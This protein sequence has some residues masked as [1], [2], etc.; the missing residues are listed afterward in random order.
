MFHHTPLLRHDTMTI[1][2]AADDELFDAPSASTWKRL[3]LEQPPT[4][5]IL[6]QCLHV[7]LHHHKAIHP[8]PEELRLRNGRFTAYVIL[9]GISASVSEKEE[10]GQLLPMSP[11]F[12]QH[13]DAL[14]C[15][16]FT[17]AHAG[18][19]QSSKIQSQ[20]DAFHHM[21]MV[22][23]HCTF[24]ALVTDFNILERAAGRE[25]PENETL[26]ADIAYTRQWANSND[27]QRCIIHVHAL[28]CSLGAMR[29]DAEPAI[30]IPHCLFLAGIASY[31]FT[32]FLHSEKD[33]PRD[34]SLQGNKAPDLTPIL[35]IPEFT[36]RGAPIPTHLFETSKAP[37]R[38]RITPQNGTA[39]G[40]D[41]QRSQHRRLDS[42]ISPGMMFTI[43]DLLQRIGHWGIARK[44]AATLTTLAQNDG[45]DDWMLIRDD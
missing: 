26:E 44:Y 16:Y 15:W 42:D 22:L 8:M 32:K 5:P 33:R 9:N 21:I 12:E 3:M 28:L 23:W 43:I 4:Q 17:F 20:P 36:L 41:P 38:S 34:A 25:G 39:L 30:H 10:A 13:F 27:A 19:S 1:P 7:N 6:N 14:M 2:P 45:D 29:L 18:E 11:T 24:M 37:S 40:N 35:D 31:T